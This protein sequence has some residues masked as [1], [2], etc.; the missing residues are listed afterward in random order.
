MLAVA[1]RPASSAMRTVE[2]AGKSIHPP[3]PP[4]LRGRD[5]SKLGGA[6]YRYVLALLK[7][8]LEP[9]AYYYRLII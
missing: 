7:I 4:C 2:V 1:A 6:S 8:F 5:I 3:M 9:N